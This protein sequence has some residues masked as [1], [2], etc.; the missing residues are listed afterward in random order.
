MFC[1]GHCKEYDGQ[2]NVRIK[3]KRSIESITKYWCYGNEEQ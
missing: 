3:E 2:G 1:N